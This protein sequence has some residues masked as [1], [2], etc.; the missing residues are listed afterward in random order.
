MK[1][2]RRQSDTLRRALCVLLPLAFAILPF[3]GCG[4]ASG[5]TGGG[6]PIGKAAVAGRAVAALNSDL[7]IA[8]A[9]V[10]LI[11]VTQ[12]RS[13]QSF[14][15]VTDAAGAFRFPE[16]PFD[17]SVATMRV[18][19]TPANPGIRPQSVGFTIA[20][21]Q[22]A[23]LIFALVP[24][25]YNISDV[26]SLNVLP[27][28]PTLETNSA[29]KITA[30]ALDKQGN[31]LP[32]SPTLLLVGDF[33]DVQPDGTFQTLS[34]GLGIYHAYWYNDLQASTTLTVSASSNNLPPPPPPR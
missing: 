15:A 32:L 11:V 33:A 2:N 16:I 34:A 13:V 24:S 20:S 19:I 10:H 8:N 4:L 30:Q 28:D 9:S 5:F 26:S 21:G 27:T 23:A 6:V 25:S 14:D 29:G 3:L 31:V 22:R 7:P 12:T 1:R 17:A 18:N